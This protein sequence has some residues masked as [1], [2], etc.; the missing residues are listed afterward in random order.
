MNQGLKGKRATP[1]SHDRV[2]ADNSLIPRR[3]LGCAMHLLGDDQDEGLESISEEHPL[4][5]GP[6]HH[7]E[8]RAPLQDETEGKA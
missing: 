1:V 7:D 2:L 5:P 8:R 4:Q 3:Q 6:K